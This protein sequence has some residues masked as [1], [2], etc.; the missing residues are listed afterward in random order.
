MANTAVEAFD[1]LS[2]GQAVALVQTRSLR[3]GEA[4]FFEQIIQGL[5]PPLTPS[6]TPIS[7][8]AFNMI[9]A[10]EVTSQA[11]YQAQYRHPTWPGGASGV[12]IGI[13]Y[14]VGYVSESVLKQDWEGTIPE[15][16]I[17]ALRRSA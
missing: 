7:D 1:Y 15:L 3:D 9:V 4:W 17:Q 2:P 11:V 8:R 6:D 14:D 16:M 10:F 13:G 5:A 12:T